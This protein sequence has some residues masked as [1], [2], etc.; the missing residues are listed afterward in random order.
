MRKIDL[1]FINIGI[2]K[3]NNNS[4]S[5]SSSSSF[6]ANQ[7]FFFNIET[8]FNQNNVKERTRTIIIKL[9]DDFYVFDR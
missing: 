9:D 4:S 5:S 6:I 2:I 7:I 1:N 3:S 8:R